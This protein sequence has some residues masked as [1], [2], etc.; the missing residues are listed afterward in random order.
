M[1]L[2][3]AYC[4]S[5]GSCVRA[6]ANE[7]VVMDAALLNLCSVYNLCCSAHSKGCIHCRLVQR[8]EHTIRVGVIRSLKGYVAIV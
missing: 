2:N 1:L 4:L 7:F 3:E 5:V 8:V 6:A